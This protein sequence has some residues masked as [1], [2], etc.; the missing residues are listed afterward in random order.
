MIGLAAIL[1]LVVA[2]YGQTVTFPF[3]FDDH[4]LFADPGILS[5][6][7]WWQSF[8]LR[9]TRP[10]T[11]LTFWAN[12]QVGGAT[13]WGYHAVNVAIHLGATAAAWRVFRRLAPPA[14]ALL[15]AAMFS[16][17]PLQTEAVCYVF[18]RAAI[19][20][21]LFCLLAWD[22]WLAERPWAATVLFGLALLAKEE[23]V[24]F[25]LFLVLIA[26]P[27]R[28]RPVAAMLGLSLAAGVRLLW[29][30]AHTAGAGLTPSPSLSYLLL[31]PSAI[32]GYLQIFVVPIGQNFD[33]HITSPSPLAALAIAALIAIAAWRFSPSGRWLLAALVLLAPTSSL[34][35]LADPAFEHRMYLPLISLTL[36]AALWLDRLPRPAQVLLVGS[37]AVLSFARARV[38]S[39]EQTLWADAAQKSPA[40]FRPKVQLARTLLRTD[41]A[42][43]EALLLDARRLEPSNPEAYVQLGILRLEQR[44]PSAALVEFD[45]ALRLAPTPDH[46]SNRAIA[47]YLLGRRGEA[48]SAFL[49]ALDLNSCHPN[50]RRNLRLLYQELGDHLR[51]QQLSVLPAGCPNLKD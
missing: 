17:H 41:P 48:E 25:P 29:V 44:N 11:W 22:Q 43:A 2:V 45:N 15:A 24:S 9:Q 12:Y 6:D 34:I 5:P 32:I 42:R 36:A 31:Q 20:A 16:L 7:G 3:H 1:L 21:T 10:L 46:H 28:W 14:A 4:A 35:P 40:K 37:L 47:L 27:V 8:R 18:A 50:A 38:W 26:R 19:L 39:S 30:A 13:P 23:A 51:V 33:H 49:R